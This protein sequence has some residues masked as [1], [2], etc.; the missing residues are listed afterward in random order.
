[1]KL[2]TFSLAAGLGCALA[3][4]PALAV[5]GGAPSAAA[6]APAADSGATAAPTVTVRSA[7][8]GA[9]AYRIQESRTPAGTGV[10]EYVDGD[11]V[12]FCV[13]WDGPQM[14][15]L[16]ALFGDYYSQYADHLKQRR[17][18]GLRGPVR[19]QADALVVESGGRMR[20]FKGR[21]YVP[22]LLPANVDL[23]TLQ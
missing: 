21:A 16:P 19:M 18:Q 13:T 14:P 15:N 8:A 17:E 9:D 23:E 20:S 1:M 11:G 2:S 4:A 12:V 10:R 3:C 6:S 22:S 5:L 7:G